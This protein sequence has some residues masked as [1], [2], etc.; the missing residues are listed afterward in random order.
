MTF[1][2]NPGK[3]VQESRANRI[4]AIDCILVDLR[5]DKAALATRESELLRERGQH[6]AN[7]NVADSESR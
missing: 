1:P 2:K 4:Y 6:L 7:M 3:T 5:K